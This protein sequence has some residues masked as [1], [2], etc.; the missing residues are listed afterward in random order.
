MPLRYKHVSSDWDKG[1]MMTESTWMKDERRRRPQS[2]A[3]VPGSGWGVKKELWRKNS[4]G[5]GG[6]LV[7]MQDEE[8][9]RS[10]AHVP[11]DPS[12]TRGAVNDVVL[13]QLAVALGVLVV[14]GFFV[15]SPSTA[16]VF[17]FVRAAHCSIASPART[18]KN[19]LSKDSEKYGH[20]HVLRH[21]DCKRSSN[22]Q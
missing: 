19:E 15:E 2:G 20:A 4:A 6:T 5:H 8:A 13:E 18:K 11:G 17:A 7:V 1:D 9:E 16:H 14:K 22:M 12:L 21:Y 3:Y 10:L